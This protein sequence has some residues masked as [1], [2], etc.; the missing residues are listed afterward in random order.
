MSLRSTLSDVWNRFQGEFFPALAEEV[1]SP[2]G[3]PLAPR[4]GSPGSI[5]ARCE[6]T[7]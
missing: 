1:G 4:P 7:L 2:A 3:E 5:P 6:M